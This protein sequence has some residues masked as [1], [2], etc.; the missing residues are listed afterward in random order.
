ML[1]LLLLTL[2]AVVQ[3]Q[4]SYVINNGTITITGYTGPGGDV[5]IPDWIPDTTNGLPVT[6]IGDFAFQN[7]TNLTGITIGTNVTSI[8]TGAF[9]GCKGLTSVTIGTNVTSIGEGAFYYCTGL[10]SATIGNSVTNIGK[11]AFPAYPVVTLSHLAWLVISVSTRSKCDNRIGRLRS[12]AA[13]VWPASQSPIASPP[14][15]NKRSLAAA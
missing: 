2:P 15:G 12:M 13:A 10:T 5:T 11:S 1:L 8:G 7:N 14:S 6:S 3:A 9:A 4:F